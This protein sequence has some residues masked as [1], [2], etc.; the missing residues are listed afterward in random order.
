MR[1]MKL[2]IVILYFSFFSRINICCFSYT[3]W[4]NT[5]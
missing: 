3:F 5:S 2:L 1:K 4:I